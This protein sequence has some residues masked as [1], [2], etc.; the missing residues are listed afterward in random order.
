MITVN[1]MLGFGDSLY[2]RAFIKQLK[3]PV[4]V[5]TPWP[6]LLSDIQNVR[7]ARPVT[8][9]RTQSKNIARQNGW[10]AKPRNGTQLHIRYGAEGIMRGMQQSFRVL[11]GV[12]DLPPL[13]DISKWCLSA[14]AP[15]VVVRPVTLRTEWMA[16]SRNPDPD[17]VAL[18]SA[19]AARRGYTVISVAD[20]EFGKEFIV[21]EA[22]PAHLEYH[23]GQLDVLQLLALVAGAAA[24]IGGIG[25]IVPACIAAKVPAW[26]V[27]GGQG[28]FN[29]PELIAPPDST[30]SFAVPDNFCRCKSKDHICDKRISNYAEK[31]TRWADQHLAVV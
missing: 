25:W 1:A 8:N 13:P 24:V 2:Q 3:G 7:C 21:G 31:F 11:P 29:A 19:E 30:V 17:Y 10:S 4:T 27:C 16:C 5:V 12:M 20:L 26:V 22:P 9:L 23:R 6:E 15:Y 28:G 18:A 14:Y